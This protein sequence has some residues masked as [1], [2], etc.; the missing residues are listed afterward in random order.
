[1][2]SYTKPEAVEGTAGTVLRVPLFVRALMLRSF[3]E[4]LTSFC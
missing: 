2:L 1:M 3:D 4:L